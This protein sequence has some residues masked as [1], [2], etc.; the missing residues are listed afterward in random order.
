MKKEPLIRARGFHVVIGLIL[1][2]VLYPVHLFG[3]TE[4]PQKPNKVEVVGGLVTVDVED[5]EI[6]DVLKRIEKGSGV[7]TIIGQGLVGKKVTASFEDK[8]IEEALRNILRGHYYVLSFTHDPMDKEKKSLR[9]VKAGG[10]EI[11]SK[12]LERL[13]ITKEISYGNGREDVGSV[14]EGEGALTGPQSFAVSDKGDIYVCDTVNKR[15]QIFSPSGNYLATIPLE[16]GVFAQDIVVDR[17]EFVYIYDRM[18]TR[19]YQYGKN[20]TMITFIDVDEGRWGGY[21][22]I[23]HIIDNEINMYVCDSIT[24]GDFIIGKLSAD[25]I[26]VGPSV[27]EARRP[28][29]QGRQGLS[30]RKYMTGLRRFEEGKLELKEKD[31]ATSKTVFFPLNNILSTEFIE[32][33]NKE[34]AYVVIMRDG[35]NEQLVVD[36]HKFDKEGNYLNTIQVPTGKIRFSSTKN[37][38]VG[39]EGTIYRFLPEKEKLTINI[40]PSETNR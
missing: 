6:S 39:K 24:C 10:P 26:L 38:L 31:S 40:F 29:D 12:L 32:E 16:T 23:M 14:D 9:E 19:L 37:L 28:R 17:R 21:G 18:T 8:D 13:V 11:G 7:K 36:V 4:N 2:F 1:L 15:V 30:G 3:Q 33:D 5:V 35:E 22:G 34:N 25:N 27:D 20:G